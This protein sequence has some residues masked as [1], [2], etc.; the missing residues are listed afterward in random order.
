STQASASLDRSPASN[1][2]GPSAQMSAISANSASL[3]AVQS[4]VS[5]S[6]AMRAD[7]PR[8]VGRA[9]DKPW[10]RTP[11]VQRSRTDR[12]TRVGMGAG[13]GSSDGDGFGSEEDPQLGHQAVR[14]VD[15][16]LVGEAQHL[17]LAEVQEHLRLA[18]V[19]AQQALELAEQGLVQG[20]G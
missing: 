19:L 14:R 8:K 12:A 16:E 2:D 7:A 6:I 10:D 18:L 5:T 11:L 9:P 13:G 17:A 3:R 15:V 1:R 20:V 4:L